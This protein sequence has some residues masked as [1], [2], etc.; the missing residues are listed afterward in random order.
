M[1]VRFNILETVFIN[2]FEAAANVTFRSTLLF[3]RA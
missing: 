1:S 2:S 3:L